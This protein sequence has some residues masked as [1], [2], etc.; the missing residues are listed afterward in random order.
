MLL[1]NHVTL[2]IKISSVHY[3]VYNCLL[4]TSFQNENFGI[5]L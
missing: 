3:E 4:F 2:G 1:D 5:L